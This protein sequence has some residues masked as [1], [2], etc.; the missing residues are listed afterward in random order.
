M[1]EPLGL[2]HIESKTQAQNFLRNILDGDHIDEALCAF[3][4]ELRNISFSEEMIAGFRDAMMDRATR[5]DL[6]TIKAI[7]IC[8]TGGDGKNT[9]NIST[10][11]ALSTAACGCPVVKHGNSA[12]SSLCGSSDILHRV[13]IPTPNTP[14]GVKAQ[15][16]K[17]GIAFLHA[18]FFHP[19][20][21]RI[22]AARR[23]VQFRTIFN[24][25][26]P[27]CNPTDPTYKVLGVS[28]FALARL[29]RAI[30]ARGDKHYAVLWDE[31]GY[32]EVTLT[33]RSFVTVNG[34]DHILM[35]QQFVK[36]PIEPRSLHG[37]KSPEEAT[38]QFLQIARGKG[39]EE[40]TA[41]VAVNAA[42]AL[43]VAGHAASFEEG[44][45][46]AEQTIRNEKVIELIDTL[47]KSDI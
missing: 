13:G 40:Q 7:D 30:L 18:P 12:F 14:D 45:Q 47:R 4:G 34:A 19:M 24:I 33:A 43:F 35:P 17:Y 31:N 37:A 42:I 6:G 25:L 21:K 22:G 11:A 44:F 32:D 15:V 41:V 20:L 28:H 1:I 3:L 46:R 10:L 39:S 23:K 16:E 9:F 26:G 8:G 2:R 5:I 29:Y 38:T 36:S 27:L